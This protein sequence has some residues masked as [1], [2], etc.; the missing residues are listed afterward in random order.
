MIVKVYRPK[1]V[2][3]ELCDG[4]LTEKNNN[5]KIVSVGGV[6]GGEGVYWVVSSDVGFDA[7]R[8]R[9]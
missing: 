9:F 8:R 6:L 1:Q 3:V 7:S 4:E 2:S 5:R